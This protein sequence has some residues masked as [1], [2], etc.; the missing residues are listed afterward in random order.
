META[1]LIV[2]VPADISIKYSNIPVATQT[3]KKE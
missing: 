2:F 3:L 1:A